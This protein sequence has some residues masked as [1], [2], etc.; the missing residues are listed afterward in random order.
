MN[1]VEVSPWTLRYVAVAVASFLL[2]QALMVLGLSYPIRPLAAPATLA[3]VHLVTIGWLTLL[4]LGVLHQFI[5]VIGAKRLHSQAASGVTFWLVAGGLVLLVLG[6]LSMPS[7]LLPIGGT[8]VL[9]GVLIAVWNL[10]VTLAAS[11]PLRLPALYVTASLCFLT[12]TVLLGVSFA[13]ALTLPEVFAPAT[14]GALLTR[15]IALHLL[16]GIGGWFG[17]TAMGVADRLLAM[18]ALAPEDRGRAR[19][20]A[21][22]LVSVGIGASWLAG[23]IL[24]LMPSPVVQDIGMLGW[25]ALFIGVALYL[26]DMRELFRRRRR[27]E[28]EANAVFGRVSLWALGVAAAM[29]AFAGVL[30]QF[31]SLAPALVYALLVGW[32]SGLA[33]SQLYKIVPFLTWLE[34]YGKTLGKTRVPRVQDLVVERRAR[35]MFWLYFGGAAVG[36]L[37]MVVVSEWLL[38]LGALLTLVGTLGIAREIWLVRHPKTEPVPSDRQ[39]A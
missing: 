33:L 25:G 36:T 3:T 18:F 29:T 19:H 7:L 39:S 34:R 31:A 28:L 26:F 16:G 38:R 17:L 2:A 4:M 1:G 6:F 15:G 10:G 12:L 13:V 23:L 27:R 37:G 32:L 24:T 8:L 11:R 30:S 35:P 21:F 9:A 20:W 22:W 5:P 14:I